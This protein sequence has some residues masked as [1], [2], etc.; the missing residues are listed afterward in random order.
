MK[1]V[2]I[3]LLIVLALAISACGGSEPVEQ[4]PTEAPAEEAAQEADVDQE[5]T[6]APP[7][8]HRDRRPPPRPGIHEKRNRQPLQP[9]HQK[10]RF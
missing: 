4:T 6:E 8:S 2:T 1:K 10:S 7:H 5:P 3:L 9:R